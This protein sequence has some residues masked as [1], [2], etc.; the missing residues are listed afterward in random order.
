MNVLGSLAS[1]P[2]A[3]P[4]L[5]YFWYGCTGTGDTTIE[6]FLEYQGDDFGWIFTPPS[7][8]G[9]LLHT[10]DED[11]ISQAI[12]Q[13]DALALM[14]NVLAYLDEQANSTTEQSTWGSLKALYR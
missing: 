10:T 13:P 6:S 5:P 14:E 9:K 4:S 8:V 11:W 1:D 7:G 12:G 2:N 3:V